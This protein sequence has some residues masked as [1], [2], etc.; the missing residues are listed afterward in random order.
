[1]AKKFIKN[2]GFPLL[3]VF[4]L[5]A[6]A[7]LLNLFVFD[8]EIENAMQKF[9]LIISPLSSLLVF[10]G[11]GFFAKGHKRNRAI[12]WISL[13]LSLI[14]VGDTLYYSFFDDFVTIPVLFMTQNFADLG[15][16]VKALIS[17]KLIL[18]F[19]DVIILIVVNLLWGKKFFTTENIK[20]NSRRAFFLVAVAVFLVN[21][22]LAEKE[23]PQLLTRSFDREY[24]VKFLGLYNYH[25]YDIAIQS[26][27]SAQKAMA[28]DSE[29]AGIEN[30]IRAN[31][32]GVNAQLHGK[33]KGKNVVVI[34]L[35]SL[36]NFVINRKINGQEI[37]PFL[38]SF[39]KDS[40]YFD[41]F[42]HQTGQGKTSD[43]EFMIDNSL[44]PLDRGAVYFTNSGNT[45]TATPA[46]LKKEQGYYTSVMHANNKSFWNRDMMYPSLGY[47]RYFNEHDFKIDPGT[48][49]GW[50]LKDEYFVKQ[51]VDLMKTL[52]QPFYNRMITLT[53]HFPFELEP[54]DQMIEKLKTGDETVDNYV[55][56][57]R[58][59]DESIKQFISEMKA[60]GLYDNTIIVMYGDH[61][62]ISE[63]HNSAMSQVLGED[64]TPAVHAKLQQTPFFIHLPGQ[65]KGETIHK[66]MGQVDVKPT[67]LNLLGVDANKT[68]VNF[69]NDVFSPKHK[70]FVVFRDGSIVTN[71]YIYIGEKMYDA[72]TG[73]LLEGQK[74]PK[75]DLTKAKK[76]LEYSNSIILKDLLRFY[77]IKYKRGNT[78]FE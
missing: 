15:S 17:Y 72:A 76:S 14:L 68:S 39:I 2:F 16:S 41:N 46:I 51:S 11:I 27:T 49:V 69:G 29:L 18:A 71:K 34:S 1:M 67:I 55:T 13:I 66:V 31:D 22:G 8:L 4:L 50:G 44:F 42:Y 23:R 19:S 64:I 21:L 63:N 28:D 9:I 75:E 77:E 40:Y 43:A 58:Y 25:L 10:I 57:V 5:W 35:E 12:I 54:K 3:A 61:Y 33:Y 24:I 59:L 47:D 56:T 32:T 52:P 6:K 36:Q 78:K 70:D 45:F 60:S 37:T 38:N 62:G 30:F 7:T 74:P 53:N 65:T 20:G 26:K 73:E 48:T